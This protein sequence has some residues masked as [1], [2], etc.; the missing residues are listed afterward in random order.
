MTPCCT[1]A[2]LTSLLQ[3]TCTTTQTLGTNQTPARLNG[4]Y[5]HSKALPERPARKEQSGGRGPRACAGRPGGAIGPQGPA[6]NTPGH[7]ALLQWW[8]SL[9]YTVG[10]TPSAV[11]FDGT[12]IW[13]VV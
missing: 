9:T 11:A 7:V 4:H 1:A 8:S 5:W 6:G 12:N 10:N 2:R 3:G 13:V